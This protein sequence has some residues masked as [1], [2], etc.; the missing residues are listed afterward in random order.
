MGTQLN[1]STTYHPQ[2]NGQIER[3]NQVLEYM[4]RLYVMDK[5]TKWEDYLHLVEFAYKNGHQTSLGMSP[6]EALY[7][8]GCKALVRWDNPVSRI[9]LGPEILKEME[10]K[11][12][13]H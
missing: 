8:R 2:T 7:G 6:F 10:Q 3:V 4:L 13:Y 11:N 1:F 5:P 9:V 12:C